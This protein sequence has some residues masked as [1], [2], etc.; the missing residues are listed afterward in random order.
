MP[1]GSSQAEIDL[2]IYRVAA[3]S[4]LRAAVGQHGF[5]FSP[6][7]WSVG[8]SGSCYCLLHIPAGDDTGVVEGRPELPEELKAKARDF[9]VISD[10]SFSTEINGKTF[11]VILIED[12]QNS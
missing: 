3:I 12:R 7:A 6:D 9:G 8:G 5:F 1:A 10:Q 11:L 4:A 2:A